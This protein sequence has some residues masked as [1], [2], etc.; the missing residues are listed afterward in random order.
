MAQTRPEPQTSGDQTPPKRRESA[1]ETFESIVFAFVLAFL[2]RT[3]EAEAFVIPTGSMAP[4]LFG[5][6]KDLDCEQCGYRFHVGASDE[7]NEESGYLKMGT[8]IT[9][10][11]CPNCRFENE[12]AENAL[13]FNGDRIL[14]NKYP[15]ELGE[16]ER[17]DVFVFKFPEEPKTNFIKRLVGL[18][19]ETVRIRDGDIYTIDPERGEQIQRKR[20][21]EKQRATQ[22]D[23][24]DDTCP[25][26]ALLENGWPERWASVTGSADGE[27]LAWRESVDGWTHDPLERR[28]Q[29]TAEAARPE[30][31]LRYRHIVPTPED[32]TAVLAG[33]PVQPRPILISDYCGYNAF[34]GTG[35]I[36]QSSPRQIDYGGF[37]VGDLTLC[38][39]LSIDEALEGAEIVLELCEGVHWY[40]C[41][42]DLAT[43]QAR[44]TEINLQMGIEQ[45]R[46]LAS[47]RTPVSGTGTWGIEFAN[48]DDRL[49]LWVDGNVVD[50]GEGAAY[51]RNKLAHLALNSDLSPVGI[52]AR[53]AAV[54]VG[55]LRLKRDIYYRTAGVR[56]DLSR[57]HFHLEGIGEELSAVLHDPQAWSEVYEQNTDAV[58][59]VDFALGPDQF[60]ALGDNS[61]KS[62]DS[63]LWGD[64]PAV[65][66]K[67]L[68]GKAFWIYWPHGVPFLNN[69]RGIPLS[70]HR[71]PGVGKV[72]DY[73]KYT[74]P[75]YPQVGRME[76][77]R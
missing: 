42:I 41:R 36:R 64:D 1:R 75:F 45:E 49:A 76:R 52:A 65:P 54:G 12:S 31:W 66:R 28:F 14:V 24:Y 43:G 26:R 23:V 5:R 13:A 38:C 62:R 57:E 71:A 32:W 7:L 21:L 53:N 2:F 47:A 3:F 27:V 63:R 39:D 67:F 35:D 8:R 20:K 61:P 46:E 70:Y 44:L 17:W 30:Q 74:V 59:Q 48:V 77:I 50:F 16:P 4:T 34:L 69:G 15:Y 37:W 10:A 58:R 11:I 6:H 55:S 9:S 60:L 56:R 33:R 68:V 72:E 40:R 18:P 25:P 22:I 73:P 51:S 29:I 19:N